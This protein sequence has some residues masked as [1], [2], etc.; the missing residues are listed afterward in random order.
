MSSCLYN[1]VVVVLDVPPVA[2]FVY[3]P[4]LLYCFPSHFVMLI[5]DNKPSIGAARCD[6]IPDVQ[7]GEGT[8]SQH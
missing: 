1:F 4:A 7:G 6:S 2:S 5:D 3:L 8:L